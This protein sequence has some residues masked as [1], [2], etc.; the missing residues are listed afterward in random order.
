V[1]QI[2]DAYARRVVERLWRGFAASGPTSETG[3]EG[4]R[5]LTAGLGVLLLPLLAIE[6]GTIPFLGSLRTVHIFV[7]V[8]LIPVVGIK[9]ASVFYR[10]ARYY[11]GNVS[12]RQAGPPPPALRMIGPFVVLTSVVLL[13][14]GV[15]VAIEGHGANLVYTVHKLS[16]F[17]WFAAMAIH[18]LGHVRS[19]PRLALLDWRRA[20]RSVSSRARRRILVATPIVAVL[21]ALASMPFLTFP[22]HHRDHG[23][24]RG[25]N[26]ASLLRLAGSSRP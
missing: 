4:N 25:A 11:T 23:E 2:G 12:Y 6:S 21:V 8:V 10:F 14:S 19:L 22:H 3:P 9:L 16:F 15:L 24:G 1:Q 17:V 18:V 7:G 26:N 20:S 13:G 5:R